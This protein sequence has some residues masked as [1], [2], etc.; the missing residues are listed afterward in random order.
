MVIFMLKQLQV[1]NMELSTLIHL[2]PNSR[3]FIFFV[4]YQWAQKV[5]VFHPGKP[6]KTVNFTGQMVIFMLKQLQVENT[7]LS[8]FIRLKPNSKHFI[9][10]VPYKWAQIIGVFDPGKPLRTVKFYSIISHRY[11]LTTMLFTTWNIS[12]HLSLTVLSVIARYVWASL[13]GIY[14]SDLVIKW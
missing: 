9:F 8:T 5:R 13:S 3:H 6:L 2:K 12:I 4:T 11:L 1:E 14:K 7:E 10:F